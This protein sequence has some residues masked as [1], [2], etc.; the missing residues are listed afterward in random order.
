MC[1]ATDQDPQPIC[2]L[3]TARA[4]DTGSHPYCV[5]TYVFENHGERSIPSDHAA[6]RGVL[7]KATIR[8]NQ[9]K[10]IPSWMSKYPVFCAIL[11]QISDGHQ[12]PDDPLAALADFKVILE[13]ARK[14]THT[15]LLRNTLG[16][17]GA[18][19]SIASTTLR[20]YRNRHLGTLMHCC[21][22]WEPVGICFDQCSFECIDFQG[23]SQ[24]IASLTRERI[25]EREAEIRSLPWTQTEK[26]NA[27]AKCR[28][29]LRSWRTKLRTTWRT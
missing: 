7:Q 27:L 12:Y 3:T 19:L 25:A 16:S 9:V 6:L 1:T 26:D 2:P 5:N 17:P 21:E 10:H 8:C 24:I 4:Q 28:L 29:G 11:K 22:A 14:Q 15:E 13:K 20:A 23:L 18:K